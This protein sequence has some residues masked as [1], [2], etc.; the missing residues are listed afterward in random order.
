MSPETAN[1]MKWH[2]NGC[3]NDMLMRHPVDSEVWKSFDS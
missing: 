3:V 2:A 1:H